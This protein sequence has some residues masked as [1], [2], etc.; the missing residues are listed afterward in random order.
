M[1]TEKEDLGLLRHGN[2]ISVKKRFMAVIGMTALSFTA[3]AA[4]NVLH[5]S[6]N[7]KRAAFSENSF[8]YDAVTGNSCSSGALDPSA[9][10]LVLNGGRL[11][12]KDVSSGQVVFGG[13]SLTVGGPSDPCDLRIYSFN[14][15]NLVFKS[16]GLF[17]YGGNIYTEVNNYAK[18]RMSGELTFMPTAEGGSHAR[19][20]PSY[21]GQTF[22]VDSK[23]DMREGAVVELTMPIDGSRIKHHVPFKLQFSNEESS[24]SGKFLLNPAMHE[25]AADTGDFVTV[26][27]PTV[28]V[29]ETEAL[30]NV[31]IETCSPDDIL[32]FGRLKLH[33]GSRLRV[34]NTYSIDGGVER[35]SHSMVSVKDELVLPADGTVAIHMPS[36]FVAFADAGGS[37]PLLS[38]PAGQIDPERF[39][40]VPEGGEFVYRYA[41]TVT[42][43]DGR[44]VLCMA[45]PKCVFL[46]QG[47][48]GG[49]NAIKNSA[50]STYSS[51]FTNR[52]SWSD[53]KLPHEG[54]DYFV[55]CSSDSKTYLRTEGEDNLERTFEGD[56]LTIGKNCVFAVFL[57][58]LTVKRLCILDGGT[59]MQGQWTRPLELCGEELSLP[60]GDV[61]FNQFDT[62]TATVKMPLSGSACINI[63]GLA[64]T[65]SPKGNIFLEA[66]SPLF[67][68]TFRLGSIWTQTM[69]DGVFAASPKWQSLRVSTAEALGGPLPGF[70]PKAMEIDRCGELQITNTTV[71]ADTTRGFYFGNSAQI[72]V[73]SGKTATFLSQWTFNGELY[74]RGAGSLALGGTVRFDS[75]EDG[76]C[77]TPR[78]TSNLLTFVEGGDL[79]ALSSGCVDGLVVAFSN[80]ASRL[81][82][83]A[84][85]SDPVLKA[86]G[87][88]NV[89]T[90]TPFVFTG[91]KLGISLALEGDEPLSSDKVHEIGLLTVTPAA[92][93]A[94]RGR[95]E[96]SVP[97]SVFPSV[98][99]CT[100]FEKADPETGNV[101]FSLLLR[102][103]GFIVNL[104]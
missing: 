68:G 17:F 39:R 57:T 18:L 93:S 65:S 52:T 7:G 4:T 20:R 14:T 60:S 81:V 67:T 85:T 26:A 83:N 43:K 99:K 100:L 90:D 91:E 30:T 29:A 23:V 82:L 74:K 33:A 77:D 80:A 28:E 11:Y 36:M 42:K 6:G 22:A 69:T 47:D 86:S 95:L 38:A 45:V 1:K 3:Y 103:Q 46:T 79:K 37:V 66:P 40:L 12:T 48:D 92:A 102:R 10:Y 70:N 35:A 59:F 78:A 24:F 63:T 71:F 50:G 8:W 16:P 98:S 51:A 101:T 88:R 13:R 58:R 61:H 96:V 97:R 62:H 64:G 15:A 55:E 21:I 25:I 89:K 87:I 32:T 76:I 84:D 72:N 41:L 31:M 56:S 75:E 34:K 73:W 5:S 54:A 9:D 27:F 53:G 44:D 94:L 49:F 19:I 2:R 104:R